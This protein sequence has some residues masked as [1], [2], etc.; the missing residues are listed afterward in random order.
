[1]VSVQSIGKHLKVLKNS[2]QTKGIHKELIKS[3]QIH[4]TGIPLLVSA[5]FLR[6]RGAGQID[7]SRIIYTK[8]EYKIEVFE[9][10]SSKRIGIKQSKRIQ[11]S[12]LILGLTFNLTCFTKVI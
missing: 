12:C 5:K 8:N 10:K 11:D 4:G 1:M 2:S 9:V 3:Q 6:I 7:I